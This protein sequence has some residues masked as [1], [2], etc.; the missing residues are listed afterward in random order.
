LAFGKVSQKIEG[1]PYLPQSIFVGGGAGTSGPWGEAVILHEFG[2]YIQNNFTRNDSPGGSH[3]VG[4]LISP[5]FAWAE[6]FSNFFGISTQSLLSGRPD[7]RLW[8]IVDYG[9]GSRS[10]WW[11]DFPG[12][13][14]PAGGFTPPVFANGM[15]QFLDEMYLT[16]MLW[17]LWDG[18]EFADDDEDGTALGTSRFLRALVSDR[19]LDVDRGAVGV[20]FVDF[21]DAVDKKDEEFLRG[22]VHEVHSVHNVHPCSVTVAFEEVLFLSPVGADLHENL[23]VHRAVE[24][25]FYLLAGGLA[26]FFDG[27]AFLADDDLLLAVALHDD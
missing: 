2:H 25:F 16:G 15:T 13:I 3:Y 23:Q 18:V 26:E 4:E 17:D 10:S 12:G 19:F 6:A 9:K 7:G 21:V 22:F 14:G 24:E 5:P 8:L 27:R 11:I 1:G 20:D